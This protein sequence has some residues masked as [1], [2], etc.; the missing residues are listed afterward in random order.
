MEDLDRHFSKEDTQMA[1]EHMERC[2]P[3]L[4]MQSVSHSVQ[5]L[6]E[7]QIKT[8]MRYNLT[9]VRVPIIKSL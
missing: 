7:L 2:L 6:R 9:A 5:S 8:I 4:I 1:N 3:S